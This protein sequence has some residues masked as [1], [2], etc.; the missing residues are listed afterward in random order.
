VTRGL[1]L[2]CLAV[3]AFLAI[4]VAG[5]LACA[6]A[7]ARPGTIADD[8][9]ERAVECL[10]NEQR[11]AAG[12]RP[13]HHDRRLARAAGRFSAAMV[14]GGFFDHISPQGSTPGQ[15]ARAAGYGSG[16]L[17]ET[18]GWGAAALATPAAIVADWMGSPPHRAIVLGAGFRRI[19][20]GVADG[21]PEG[22]AG[23]ATV[24][25]EFGG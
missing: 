5:A 3:A 18:I 15:R 21:S 24:T 16:V 1:A 19:G 20:P 14:R 9:Y 2:L 4:P 12:L 6:G 23:A 25:A 17:G 7:G 13:L 11:A 8:D 22:V 10:V